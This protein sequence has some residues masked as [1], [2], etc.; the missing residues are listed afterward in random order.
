MIR[1]G[2]VME[3][4][5]GFGMEQISQGERPKTIGGT[6]KPVAAG[7]WRHDYIVTEVRGKYHGFLAP[8]LLSRALNNKTHGA[9]FFAFI[10]HASY[11]TLDIQHSTFAISE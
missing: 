4:C 5:A 11:I 9:P 7:E 8:G 10:H 1:L 3:F 6:Q 2:R